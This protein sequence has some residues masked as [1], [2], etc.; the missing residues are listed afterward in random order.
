[1]KLSTVFAMHLM[2]LV[3][4]QH[5]GHLVEVLLFIA[6]KCNRHLSPILWTWL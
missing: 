3:V 4:V 5:I 2:A 6:L 1:M